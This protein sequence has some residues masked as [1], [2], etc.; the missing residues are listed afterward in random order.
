VESADGPE[1]DNAPQTRIKTAPQSGWSAN[2]LQD[3]RLTRYTKGHVEPPSESRERA[4]A[5]LRCYPTVYHR[6]S[7]GKSSY[8]C[9]I[10]IKSGLREMVMQQPLWRHR[11]LWPTQVASQS[12]SQSQSHIANIPMPTTG[13]YARRQTLDVRPE[14]DQTINAN[15]IASLRL[16][17]R[18][19]PAMEEVARWRYA[20]MWRISSRSSF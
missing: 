13:C 14:K 15:P 3:L 8:L 4:S 11:A 19:T 10:L 16:S 7:T 2:A 5:P 9:N 12:H 1:R 17:W 6:G 20:R 18:D